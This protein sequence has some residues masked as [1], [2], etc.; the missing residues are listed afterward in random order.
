LLENIHSVA[1]AAFRE[2]GLAVRRANKSLGEDELIAQLDGVHLLGIR[3]KTHVTRRVLEAPSAQGLLAVGAFCIGT[4][5][6]ALEAARD[7]GVCVFNAPF[8]NTRSVA[9]LVLAEIVMLS[10][11]LGDRTGEIHR[12]I[13]RKVASGAH[14]VRGKTLG[15]VGYG[16]IGTQVGILAEFFGMRVLFYDVVAKLPLGNCPPRSSLD[17]LL[18]ESDF[19]T[20]HVPETPQTKGM[21]GRAQLARMK[22]G[23]ALI[24]ASRGTV[25]DLDALAQE[26]RSGRLA[27]AAIDVYPEEPQ[28]N[29]ATGFVSPLQGLAHVVLTPHIGGSTE[30]AQEAIGREVSASLVKYALAGASTGTVNFPICELPITPGTW[31][32]AHVHRNVPG[33]L[34]DVNRVVSEA[35]ANVHAQLLSTTPEVGYLLMDLDSSVSQQVVEGLKRL[36]TT[37]SARSLG[38]PVGDEGASVPQPSGDR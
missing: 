17:A 33:V 14:E 1:E 9:E 5:Q 37:L 7:R 31:R 34:R 29:E 19:V 10:R 26:L 2:A 25:V 30:E 36:P 22:R 20:L 38:A 24:N 3:S 32:L 13:W 6:V 4:N 18:A 27:G 21:M 28:A 12:G 16:H 23:A 35:G 15:V 11:Q 8:S